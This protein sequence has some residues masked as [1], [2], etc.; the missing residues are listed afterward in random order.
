MNGVYVLSMD[1]TEETQARVA[2]QQTHKREMA[3]QL[4]NGLAHDFANLLTIILGMQGKLKKMPLPEDAEA[5]ITA[6]L[7]AAR[8]G[9]GRC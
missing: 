3:A 2:L 8:R 6:T 4:T 9:G 1:V 5:L 7:S